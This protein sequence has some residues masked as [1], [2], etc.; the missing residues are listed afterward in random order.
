M[1]YAIAGTAIPET[2][3]MTNNSPSMEN[4][5]GIAGQISSAL[6]T[7]ENSIVL[8]A[9]LGTGT[10][11]EK[12]RK[13]LR[14][15][16]VRWINSS[17]KGGWARITL[18]P[19]GTIERAQGSWPPTPPCTHEFARE[20]QDADFLILSTQRDIAI[21]RHHLAQ[22]NSQRTPTMLVVAT[23]GTAA[24]L[25]ETAQHPKE[26]VSM[27]IDE[28]K[29][30][31]QRT[32]MRTA[33]NIRRAVNAQNMLV[34][35]GSQGWNLYRADAPGLRSNAPPAPENSSFIGC[36]DYA[37]AG[38]CQAIAEGMDDAGTI[39]SV[40]AHIKRKIQQWHDRA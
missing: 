5:G 38:L 11:A 26:I 2:I 33:D 14:D 10:N 40:N 24:T 16:E 27:N 22:A 3:V 19:D 4:A 34:T 9:S 13:L 18:R 25:I 28:F 23:T 1:K 29:R 39:A 37:A 20:I 30:I 12:I 8:H 6:A 21:I 35:T 15:Q 7:S 36:G 31:S 32:G 17:A